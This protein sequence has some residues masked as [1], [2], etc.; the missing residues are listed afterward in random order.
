[1]NQAQM[2]RVH[3]QIDR[4][5]RASLHLEQFFSNQN[6]EPFFVKNLENVQGDERDVIIL[7]VG[8][9][10]SESGTLSHNFGPLN[11][12]G[13]ERR[14]NVAITR[15]R[16]SLKIFASIRCDDIDL[17]RTQAQGAKLL[18]AYL[19]FAERGR[20]ALASTATEDGE[21]DFDSDFEM[22]VARA[23]KDR[24]LQVHRQIGCSGFRIDLALV[25]PAHPG[26]YVLGV[27]CDGATYHSSATARDRDRLRQEILENLGWKICR[28]WSTDWVRDP[29]RQIQK[30]LDL[31]E[32][33]V[34]AAATTEPPVELSPVL[35]PIKESAPPAAQLNN[36]FP[37]FNDI[38][39]VSGEFLYQALVG[40]IKSFGAMPLDDLIQAATR[41]L[42]FR[43]TGTRIRERVGRE[44][45][46]F[47]RQGKLITGSDNLIRLA[48]PE[49]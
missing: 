18:R 2:M 3:E 47:S 46:N 5:R 19:D 27:E 24:G 21:H 34:A 49:V 38:A 30:V 43:R 14:L 6:P 10:K 1:M 29:H 33:A 41:S 39:D 8:Y 7:G 48:E 40:S 44:I 20:A 45:R 9:A 15:A 16:E 37:E 32:R 31:Y 4:R 23:L 26:Q 36:G 12:Q 42:G 11:R 28:V 22:E 35:T 25:H 13:G 17:S